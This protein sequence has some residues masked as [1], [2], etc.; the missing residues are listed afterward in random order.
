MFQQTTK[1]YVYFQQ[2]YTTERLTSNM[3]QNMSDDPL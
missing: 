1:F 2:V 3:T